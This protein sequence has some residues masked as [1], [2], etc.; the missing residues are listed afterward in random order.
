MGLYKNTKNGP[1]F[2]ID[3][4]QKQNY[5]LTFTNFD[6]LTRVGPTFNLNF[7]ASFFS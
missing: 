6:P 7:P 1:Q 5:I 2:F 3:K 4:I